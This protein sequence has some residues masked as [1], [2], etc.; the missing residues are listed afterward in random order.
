LLDG[1]VADYTTVDVLADPAIREGI[2][3][4]SQWPTIPQ[5]YVRGEFIG[6]C[7]IVQE[8]DASGE[9]AESLGVEPIEVG[10]PPEIEITTAAATALRE[11]AQSAPDDA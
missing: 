5:L 6:G 10:E 11:A 9:L 2:K 1:M 4:Y 3:E 7:D 8:L